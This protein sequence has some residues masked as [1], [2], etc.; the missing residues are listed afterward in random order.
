MRLGTKVVLPVLLLVSALLRGSAAQPAQTSLEAPL[1]KAEEVVKLLKASKG[2][3]PLILQVGFRVLYEQAHIPG[4]EYVA[5]ASELQGVEALRR[6]L[7]SVPRGKTIIL[8]CG[9]CPWVKCPN[10]QPAFRVL[11]DM[12]F[13]NVK[14]LYIAKN[15]GADWVDQGYPVEKSDAKNASSQD[16]GTT[17]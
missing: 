2:A 16:G 6:R 14:L 9:C 7:K 4:S 3:K 1:V 5:A 10:V 17:R 8:Y 13:T 11:R 12:G 15:F